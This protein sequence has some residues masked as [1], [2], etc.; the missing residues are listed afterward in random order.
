MSNYDIALNNIYTKGTKLFRHT[1]IDES[2]TA[3]GYPVVVYVLGNE[4]KVR[5]DDNGG[6]A[7]R[8]AGQIGESKNAYFKKW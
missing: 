7:V 5:V 4:H 3:K 2:N 8:G 6:K 1:D